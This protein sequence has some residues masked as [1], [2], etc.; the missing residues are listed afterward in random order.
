MSPEDRA[1]VVAIEREGQ[2]VRDRWLL[3]DGHDRTAGVSADKRTVKN[4]RSRRRW[5]RVL[6]G[7]AA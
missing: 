6:K 2:A 3:Y 4:R 5:A 7:Y 1:R